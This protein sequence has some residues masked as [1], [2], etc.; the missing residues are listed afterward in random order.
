MINGQ[1]YYYAVVSYDHGDDSLMIAPSECPKTLTLNPETNEVITD[2]NTLQIVPRSP[3]AG[4]DPGHVSDSW[5]Q[6]TMGIATGDIE[7][8]ILDP[9]MIEDGNEF[10]IFFNY[11]CLNNNFA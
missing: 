2:L 1:T 9:R 6:H 7:I 11:M 4:Y 10:R 3:S 8:E 5:V